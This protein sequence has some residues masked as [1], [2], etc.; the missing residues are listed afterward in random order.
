[1]VGMQLLHLNQKS[2]F[3]ADRIMD[4]F[5]KSDDICFTIQKEISPLIDITDF[6]GMYQEGGRPPVSPRLLILVLIMQYIERLS[7]RAA[8]ANLRYRIDWK[9]AFGL[10]LEFAG[11]HATTLVYFRE[12]LL[13][14][15]RA[16]YA[17]DK[18]LEHLSRVGLVKKNAKQ[19]IDSTHVIGLVRE[20]SRIELLHETLRVFCND[21]ESYKSH[22]TGSVLLDHFDYYTD[23]ISIRGISDAQKDRF[24]K[25]AGQA[26][27]GFIAWG[28]S[29][30]ELPIKDLES[31]KTLAI[32]FKQ[33]F[34]SE[35]GEPPEP[36]KPIKLK[37]VATG[38]DHVSS[39]HE[40]DARYGNKGKKEWIGYKAQVAET[41]S[42][43][44]DDVNFITFIDVSDAT[45]YD[46]AVVNDFI[47]D[48]TNRDILPSVVYGDTHYNSSDNITAAAC[49]G[50]ELKGPV[51]PVPG[52]RPDSKN[53]GFTANLKQNAITCPGGN[54][55]PI[56]SQWKDG[57]VR[58]TFAKETCKSC[59]QI[60]PCDPAPQGKHIVLRPESEL[61]NQRRA[62]METL[63]FEIEMHRRNGIEGTLSGL[64]RGQGMRRSRH[65]GKNKLQLQLKFTGAA[66]NILRLHRK[67]QT[68]VT[69][70][71]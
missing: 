57:R 31:F 16:S 67:R 14:N 19:R 42:D 66:A 21:I 61:L 49:K 29:V 68:E 63:E 37:K 51:S 44:P 70:A 23:K 2:L 54:E 36:T 25:D 1:M 56:T 69:V 32:V 45:D 12:R 59:S 35:D 17:F 30:K 22:L 64:V 47:S 33:N 11:I 40:P 24:V 7:D 15:D 3:S 62:L 58:A 39:P 38:K 9:I 5:L 28:E 60:N 53:T 4:D 18:V 26:M 55:A 6:E 52:D 48:Q 34:V 27:Q 8:A 46:G 65:R 13:A 71:A 20:L 50:V 41:T 10:E 43:E